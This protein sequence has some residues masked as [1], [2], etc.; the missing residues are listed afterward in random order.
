[1][2]RLFA[3]ALALLIAASALAVSNAP[4]VAGPLKIDVHEKNPWNH[5]EL[6]NRPANFQFAIVTDRTGGHRP[7]IFED[8]VARINLL[9]PEFVMSVGDLIEGGITDRARID[10]EW[11]EFNGFI[12][13]LE[14]PF[15]YVPGNHDLAN[16]AMIPAWQEQFGRAYYHFVYHDVLFV[17]LNSED[18][19]GYSVPIKDDAGKVLTVIK[20]G[21]VAEEQMQ[22]LNQVLKENADVRWT[23]VFIHKPMWEYKDKSNWSDVEALLGD[24]K[25][26]VFAGHEHRYRRVKVGEHLYYTLA[27]TGGATALRGADVGEFD[28]IA[29]VTMTPQGPRLANLMLEGIWSEDPLGEAPQRSVQYEFRQDMIAQKALEK[30]AKKAADD[31]AKAEAEKAAKDKAVKVGK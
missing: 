12:K 2:K 3:A 31:K 15:F 19:P 21:R 18:P 4:Q 20:P 11:Q 27:T 7:G 14:M 10:Q 9:Q 29:W 30:A 26:T 17:A 6:K 16:K 13:K 22:W 25:R 8:A 1:M 28:H 5:L 23:I 24:R